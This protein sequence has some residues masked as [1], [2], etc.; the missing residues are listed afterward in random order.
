M[1]SP[2]NTIVPIEYYGPVVLKDNEIEWDNA[3]YNCSIC[4]FNGRLLKY[5]FYFYKKTL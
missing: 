4:P 5:L 2:D 1:S 3:V